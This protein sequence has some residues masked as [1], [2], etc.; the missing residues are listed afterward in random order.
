MECKNMKQNFGMLSVLRDKSFKGKQ[1]HCKWA[2]DRDHEF[3]SNGFSNGF[4]TISKRWLLEH[5]HNQNGHDDI[6]NF[7]KKRLCE[8]ADSKYYLVALNKNDTRHS[9]NEGV[10][11][12]RSNFD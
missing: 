5:H 8:Y 2:D 6:C 9:S 11:Y 3:I 10:D 12:I 7:N 4:L 1:G